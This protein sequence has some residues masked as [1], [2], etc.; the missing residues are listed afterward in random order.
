MLSKIGNLFI[1]SAEAA[2]FKQ[3]FKPIMD[4]MMVGDAPKTITNIQKSQQKALPAPKLP[5]KSC[6][7]YTSPSPRDGLLSRMPSSA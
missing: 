5:F 2:P 7:L 1:P 6:L 3:V 4:W